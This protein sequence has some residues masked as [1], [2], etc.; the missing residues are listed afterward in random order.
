MRDLAAMRGAH[1]PVGFSSKN[2]IIGRAG[3]GLRGLSANSASAAEHPVEIRDFGRQLSV[4][5]VARQLLLASDCGRSIC[6]CEQVTGLSH[7]YVLTDVAYWQPSALVAD[8]AN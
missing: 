7:H 5:T 3:V 6:C 8:K 2:P 1:R 4:L